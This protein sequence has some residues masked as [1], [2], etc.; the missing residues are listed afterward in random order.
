MQFILDLLWAH[1]RSSYLSAIASQEQL[2]WP[3]RLRSRCAST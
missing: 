3:V 1:S 2:L